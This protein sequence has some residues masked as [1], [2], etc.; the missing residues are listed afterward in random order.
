M[1][2]QDSSDILPNIGVKKSK[3]SLLGA[4]TNSDGIVSEFSYGTADISPIRGQSQG[5]VGITPGLKINKLTTAY[6]DPE[7]FN[8]SYTKIQNQANLPTK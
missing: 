8:K 6:N 7:P 4:N 2:N 3:K 5:R 1:L